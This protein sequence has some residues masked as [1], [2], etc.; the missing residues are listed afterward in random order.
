M[1]ASECVARGCAL[2]WDILSPTF[3][4]RDVQVNESFSYSIALFWKGSG[5]DSQNGTGDNVQSTVV[6]PAA[7]GNEND[8]NMHDARVAAMGGAE[9]GVPDPRDKPVQMETETKVE[10]QKTKVKKTTIPVAELVYGAMQPGDVQK[11]VEKECEMALQD[12]VT[13]TTNEKK[14]VVEA[15]VYDMR[16]KLHDK[17]HDLVIASDKEEVSAQL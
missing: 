12:R 17:Y 11:A 6:F 7:G 13:D 2:Q 9:N 1:H 14:N 4:V 5:P 3:K 8:V 15:Y 16:N 10:T